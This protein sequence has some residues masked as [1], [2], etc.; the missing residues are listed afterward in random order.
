[1]CSIWLVDNEGQGEREAHVQALHD[2]A[3]EGRALCDMQK[4]PQAQAAP[5]LPLGGCAVT[6]RGGVQQLRNNARMC[7]AGRRLCCG[8]GL[9]NGDGG[10]AAGMW[11]GKCAADARGAAA[12]V[13]TGHELARGGLQRKQTPVSKSLCGSARGG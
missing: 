9:V 8:G 7:A 1:M 5:G 13:P 6:S 2:G 10:S 3:E 11:A 12:H 4:G